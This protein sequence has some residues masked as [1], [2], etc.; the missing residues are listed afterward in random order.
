MNA[1]RI[2]RRGSIATIVPA[3]DPPPGGDEM[4]TEAGDNL[5]TESG[6]ALTQET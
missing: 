3:D 6:D 2:A 1:A 5:N 4:L